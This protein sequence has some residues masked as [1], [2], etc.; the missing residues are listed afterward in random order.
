MS[1]MQRNGQDGSGAVGHLADEAAGAA[2]GASERR[3]AGRGDAG[4]PDAEIPSVEAVVP[5]MSADAARNVAV[6]PGDIGQNGPSNKRR[7]L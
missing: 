1:L 6:V 5:S 2:A 3:P 4:T 7:H